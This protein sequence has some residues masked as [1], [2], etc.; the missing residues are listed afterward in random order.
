V[1]YT[2]GSWLVTGA[3]GFI[4]G[5]LVERLVRDGM[6]VHCVASANRPFGERLPVGSGIATLEIDMADPRQL[7]AVIES[8]RPEVIINLAAQG[9]DPTDRDH[10][11]MISG[12]VEILAGL[13]DALQE[14]PPRVV[15][16]MG[17]WSEYANSSSATLIDESH[18]V[19]P[20]SIY[21]A[22]KAATT[23]YG[24][25]LARQLGIP[26]VV[27]RLFNVFGV[28][29]GRQRLIPYLIDCLSRDE[30]AELTRGDQSRDF[31][32]VT[33][34]VEA[35]MAAASTEHLPTGAYNVCSGRPV[36]VRHVA[37]TV[38]HSMGKPR[39]L[40]RFGARPSRQ[41]EPL[42]MVGDNTRFSG[43]TGW[44]PQISL[45]EGIMRMIEAS[46]PAGVGSE[47]R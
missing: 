5:H 2:E 25:A 12:N 14:I 17:S 37:Q 24:T 33:D 31:L 47:E 29:E 9:V 10:R 27:L 41:E 46:K 36:D 39:E 45:E 26:L 1:S 20:V 8:I 30:P 6:T 21:G 42:W 11:S 34:V 44:K 16:H 18:P 22:A 43:A 38:A 3:T 4:G 32:Y 7:G 35:I 19:F 28:G 15:L 40:L 23:I 13:L